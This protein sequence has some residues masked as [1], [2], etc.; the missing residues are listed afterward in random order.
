MPLQLDKAHTSVE[1]SVRHMGIATVRGRFEEFDGSVELDAAGNLT[2]VQGTIN[3]QSINTREPKRDDHL[4]SADFFDAAKYPM[5]FRS[6]QIT[7]TGPSNYKIVGDLTMHGQTHPVELEAELTGPIRDPYGNRRIG[8]DA[9]GKLNRKDWGINWNV[10]LEAGGIMVSDIV[11]LHLEVEAVE[12]QAV[13]AG[14]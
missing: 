9:T 2:S 7:K 1:F 5:E 11:N 10:A 3:P 6:T 8:I 12:M 14:A 13:Q 4:R